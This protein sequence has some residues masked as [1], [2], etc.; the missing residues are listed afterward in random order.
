MGLLTLPFWWY[1]Y[2]YNY[3]M[4]LAG[5]GVSGQPGPEPEPALLPLQALVPVSSLEDQ[6]FCRQ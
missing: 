4:Y 6:L 3:V 1:N 2:L 5:I